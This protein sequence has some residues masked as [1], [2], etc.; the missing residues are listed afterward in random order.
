MRI[1]HTS[2]ENLREPRK[3]N[4]EKSSS[5][6]FDEFTYE[7]EKLDEIDGYYTVKS[8][9][10]ET[11]L[12]DNLWKDEVSPAIYLTLVEEWR[13]K[14]R[15]P[16]LLQRRELLAHDRFRQ[17][18]K[19]HNDADALSCQHDS[20]EVSS[21]N[22]E[23]DNN[24]QKCREWLLSL[25]ECEEYLDEIEPGEYTGWSV[26]EIEL[27][28][29]DDGNRTIVNRL[30]TL[31][32]KRKRGETSMKKEVIDKKKKNVKLEECVALKNNLL[33]RVVS[34]EKDR[35]GT[36]DEHL[37]G[38]QKLSM[39]TGVELGYTEP[40]NKDAINADRNAHLGRNCKVITVQ[41]LKTDNR[42]SR[43]NYEPN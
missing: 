32:K 15:G 36:K 13:R 24:A 10:N 2:T 12:Y 20:R 26:E 38:F 1:S 35:Y 14:G 34:F 6:M 37:T 19:K 27:T 28:A 4:W 31:P 40:L 16:H 33:V 9:D 8:S 18:G 7:N 21:N 29:H 3:D 43:F 22:L 23:I 5:D 30:I 39:G 11:D 25:V 42:P 17:A 41:P